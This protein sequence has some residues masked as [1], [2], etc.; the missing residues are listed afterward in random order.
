MKILNICLQANKIL[1]A[2]LFFDITICLASPP[3]LDSAWS[4]KKGK[5]VTKASCKGRIY[6]EEI[7]RQV[8][9]DGL[10][11]YA[12]RRK[13]G[14]SIRSRRYYVKVMEDM[15]IQGPFYYFQIY[16]PERF[17]LFILR[18]SVV[19]LYPVHWKKTDF[20]M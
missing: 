9:R 15:P 5:Q 10:L 16:S 17:G 11:Y 7:I 19:F 2:L 3:K 20:L 13:E 12:Q 8:T 18:S 1:L 6:E 14:F 4:G